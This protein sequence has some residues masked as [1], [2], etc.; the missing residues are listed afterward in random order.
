PGM[1][2]LLILP[3][4]VPMV[5][6]VLSLFFRHTPRL[7]HT[8]AMAGAL[9]H[10]AGTGLLLESVIKNG[11]IALWVGG[12]PAPA[13]ICLVA[14]LLSA[15]LVVT[16]AVIHLAVMIYAR[17]DMDARQIRAGFHAFMQMLTA[18]VC[19]AFLTGDL[20]NLYVWFEVM[21]MASF[22]I[23]VMD[24]PAGRLTS[25]VKYVTLN[26]V[27][28]LMLLT[29]IGL[30][31]GLTGTLNLA[32]LHE[33]TLVVENTAALTS[34][35]MLLMTAFGIKAALFPLFFWLPAAY[36]TLPAGVTAFFGGLLTKVGVYALIRLFTLVF[37]SQTQI[38][39]TVLMAAA[40][41]T[42]VSGVVTAASQTDI[43]RILSFHIISQVGYMVLGLAVFTPLAL[44]AALVYMV[45]NIIAKATLFLVGGLIYRAAGSFHLS[46]I[47][48]LYKT[49]GLLAVLFFIPAFALAGFPPFSG[50]WAKLLIIYACLESR[51]YGPAALAA[52]VGLLTLFSMVKIWMEAFWKPR[53]RSAPDPRNQPLSPWM[54]APVICLCLVTVLMGIFFE[55]LLALSVAAGEQI[56]DPAAYVL[57]V[58]AGK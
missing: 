46:Q 17:A 30:I 43:R 20:F 56:M 28:T 8:A 33:K 37:V 53:P 16:T 50:F 58:K 39:H 3:I 47:G 45:H 25:A 2:H 5:S 9:V 12:W 14:D 24:H 23:L 4:L 10:F 21:L 54:L 49:H 52:G 57:A 29:G 36:H 27:S 22:G 31:Y 15:V 55:P 35:A 19:G 1:N 44:A 51:H 42:M 18:A 7:A 13:G 32:D 48:S 38:T 26:I 41:M 40:L 6:A 34:T 11:A